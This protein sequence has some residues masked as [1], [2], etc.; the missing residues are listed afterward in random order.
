MAATTVDKVRSL[1]AGMLGLSNQTTGRADP[2]QLKP[3]WADIIE[4]AVADAEAWIRT[5]L[6]RRF[7]ATEIATWP[8]FNHYHKRLAVWLAGS[9]RRGE[10]SDQK[11]SALDAFDCRAEIEALETLGAGSAVTVGK[12]SVGSL[13]AGLF[14]RPFVGCGGLPNG[15]FAAE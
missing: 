14:N 8:M 11:Q 15:P 5:T 9:Y 1:I 10:F 7:P 2:S 4:E 3:F 12:S 13:S 6:G